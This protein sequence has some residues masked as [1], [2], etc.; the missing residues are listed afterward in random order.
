MAPPHTQDYKPLSGRISPELNQQLAE[1]LKNTIPVP[2][3]HEKAVLLF[4]S[5]AVRKDQRDAVRDIDGAIATIKH[6]SESLKTSSSSSS[7]SSSDDGEDEGEGVVKNKFKDYDHN[8]VVL[9]VKGNKE[10]IRWFELFE[11]L[12]EEGERRGC[13]VWMQEVR[14]LKNACNEWEA[15]YP[16]GKWYACLEKMGEIDDRVIKLWEAVKK[17]IWKLWEEYEEKW[18]N[19]GGLTRWGKENGYDIPGQ[20]SEDAKSQDESMEYISPSQTVIKEEKHDGL[21]T[22][23]LSPTS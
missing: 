4:F 8:M 20:E 19:G 12:I 21:M 11:S 17:E 2:L 5:Q 1:K 6:A 15:V 10:F 16:D 22:P 7:S 18:R 14:G 13:E 3:P 23:V 9:L